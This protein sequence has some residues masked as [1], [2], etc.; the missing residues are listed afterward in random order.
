MLVWDWFG[1]DK[2]HVRTHYVELVFLLLVGSAGHVVHSSASGVR[3]IDA[4]FFML[5]LD[6]YRI[7]KKVCWD[8]L[9]QTC[10][11]ASTGICGPRSAFRSIRATKRRCTIFHAYVGPVQNPQKSVLGHVTLNLCFCIHWDLWVT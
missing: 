5:R 9:C 4:L 3:N 11:F 6:R 7:H 1:F 10:V 2:K 8:T